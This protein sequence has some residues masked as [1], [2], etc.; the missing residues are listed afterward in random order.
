MVEIVINNTEYNFFWLVGVVLVHLS[1]VITYKWYISYTVICNV[2]WI[3]DLTIQ[4]LDVTNDTNYTLD[5]Q[6]SEFCQI[7][8]L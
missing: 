5:Y 2:S 6:G 8:S 4:D 1:Y 3:S 7:Q